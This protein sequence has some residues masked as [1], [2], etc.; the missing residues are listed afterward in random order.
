MKVH[1]NIILESYTSQNKKTH[2]GASSLLLR[3]VDENTVVLQP[4]THSLIIGHVTLVGTGDWGTEGQSS[5]GTQTVV[6]AVKVGSP[7]SH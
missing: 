7:S 2:L 4:A 1:P 6:T 3:H 5:V